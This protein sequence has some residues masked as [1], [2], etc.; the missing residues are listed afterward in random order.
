[1][2]PADFLED[3]VTGGHRIEKFAQFEGPGWVFT[4]FEDLDKV[5]IDGLHFDCTSI[6]RDRGPTGAVVLGNF[7]LDNLGFAGVPITFNDHRL[8]AC[9]KGGAP[10]TIAFDL[11]H[12]RKLVWAGKFDEFCGGGKDLFHTLVIEVKFLGGLIIPFNAKR[13]GLEVHVT[14]HGVMRIEAKLQQ[15]AGIIFE[16]ECFVPLQ[17][18]CPGRWCGCHINACFFGGVYIVV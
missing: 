9:F 4:F 8:Y 1:M 14:A 2:D 15:V 11:A 6:L 10:A 18:L 13:G 7:R 17:Q 3:D 16:G 12:T 5:S